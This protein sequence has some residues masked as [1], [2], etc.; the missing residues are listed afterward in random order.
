MA[1][2]IGEAEQ[3]YARSAE[4]ATQNYNAA[5]ATM[6][7]HWAEGESDFLGAPVSARRT[8]KYST[9]IQNAQYRTGDPAKWRRRTIEAMT[10]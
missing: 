4:Y 6:P 8:Q 10:R 9:K 1:K 3:N 7:Q 5:K 2:S